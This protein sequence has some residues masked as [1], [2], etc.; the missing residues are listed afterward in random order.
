MISPRPEGEAERPSI[1]RRTSLR[2]RTVRRAA[3][4]E[5]GRTPERAAPEAALQGAGQVLRNRRFLMLFLSQLLTQVGGNMVLFGLTVQVFQLTQQNRSVSILLL[6]FLVPAVVFGAVAGVYVDRIDRRTILVSTNVLRGAAFVALVLVDTNVPLIYV[7]TAIVATLTTF[8]APA[9]AAMIP[10][11]VERRQLLAAN[12]LFVFTLQASFAIGFAVLGP[13]VSNLAGTDILILLVAGFYLIAGGLCWLL[14]RTPPRSTEGPAEALDDAQ[15]AVAATFGQLRE[16]LRYIRSNRSIFWS[17]T[18]LTITSSLI[19]VLGVLGPGF[20]LNALGLRE[21]D[22]VVVVLPL[23]GGLVVGILLLSAYGRLVA[24]RRQIEA[25]LIGLA[26]T[27]A[28]LSAAGPISRLLQRADRIVDLGPFVSLL[29]VVVIVAFL[30]GIAYAVIAVPAQTQLQEDLP[31]AVRGRVFGVL[32]MLVSIASFLPIVIVG[33]VADVIGIPFV[34]F[35][36]AAFVLVTGIASLLAAHPAASEPVGP[37]VPLEPVD[38]IT[39]AARPLSLPME[40]DV[41]ADDVRVEHPHG[42]G[43][44]AH[45]SRAGP[46][47]AAGAAAERQG[48]DAEPDPHG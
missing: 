34:L 4:R 27:L 16:G 25:G 14:P 45:R 44:G 15:H 9:E 28:I 43:R 1:P 47:S 31:P 42:E 40:L 33:P 10:V 26:V 2:R 39:L 3:I 21:Q 13:L 36:C 12:G 5:P 41:A 7:L 22:F 17:L 32:N 8:F 46:E 18:Y 20:A 24:R 23:G 30:A 35:G 29:S 37:R 19:G 6:T 11:L 38:P 48:T